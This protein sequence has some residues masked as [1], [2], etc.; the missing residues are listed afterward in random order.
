MDRVGELER[1]AKSVARHLRAENK[2]VRTI[3]TYGET[4][5]QL[6]EHL[7][8]TGSDG[9][10]QVTRGDLDG[11]MAHLLETRSG[12]TAAD[13]FR[14]VQQFFGWLVKAEHIAS[15]PMAKMR[16][17]HAPEE[18]VNPVAEVRLLS[19]NRRMFA[20]S[21]RSSNCL[22]PEVRSRGLDGVCPNDAGRAE[23]Q[24]LRTPN[25]SS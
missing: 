9:V 2:S 24:G 8:R 19:A 1:L 14:A 18:P 22:V 12:A 5:N 11:F 7:G 16:A 23:R 13:R 17:P 3:E 6:I 15:S 10:G 21:R 25:G 20:S 4:I